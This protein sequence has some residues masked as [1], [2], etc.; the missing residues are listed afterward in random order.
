MPRMYADIKN[1]NDLHYA[2][3]NG[4]MTIN[5]ALDIEKEREL[6]SYRVMCQEE[7]DYFEEYGCFEDSGEP[8]DVV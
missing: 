4:I 2:V 6:L 8:F 3:R 7:E 5:E 1:H